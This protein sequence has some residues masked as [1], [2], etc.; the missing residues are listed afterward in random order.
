MRLA[1]ITECRETPA[2][3]GVETTAHAN[4]TADATGYRPLLRA[5]EQPPPSPN[6]ND[7]RAT[8]ALRERL[9]AIAARRERR[10]QLC[11]PDCPIEIEHGDEELQQT[12]S[13]LEYLAEKRIAGD[14]EATATDY[15]EQVWQQVVSLA[16]P[17]IN[18][19]RGAAGPR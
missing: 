15:E 1:T 8:D 3:P 12:R 4:V 9:E 7:T 18:D 6:E 10:E 14:T 2:Q 19:H 16:V 13:G 17:L 5:P 11:D